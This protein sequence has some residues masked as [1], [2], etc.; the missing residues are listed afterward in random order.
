VL[1]VLHTCSPS[2]SNRAA[3][4]LPVWRLHEFG[5]HFRPTKE[6]VA[7]KEAAQVTLYMGQASC[8]A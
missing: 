6:L 1:H 8:V 7:P 2:N 5:S 4:Q 3:Q